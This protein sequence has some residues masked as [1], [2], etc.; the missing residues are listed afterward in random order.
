MT[1]TSALFDAYL[2]CPT[3]CWLR[4]TKKT[5]TGNTYAEWVKTQNESY[6]VVATERLLGQTPP[7]D[8]VLSP[9]IENLK[10]TKWRLALDVSLRTP[11]LPR[12]SRR[13][14][15]HSSFPQ[16]STL[17]S[18]PFEKSFVTSAAPDQAGV[19]P[20][21]CTAETH[22]HS[23]ER[24]PSEV[25]GKAA[26]FIPIRF[27]FTNKMGK[28]DKLLLA[29]DSFVLTAALGREI[30]FGKIIHGDDHATLKVKTSALADEVRKRLKKIAALLYNPTSPDLVLNR[31]CAECEFQARCRQKALE[32][33]DLSLL[34]GMNE[35]ERK[36]LH[37]KGI[38]TVTQLSYKFRPRRRPK[39][40]RDSLEKYH[41][42]LKALAI[43]EKKIYIVG[44]PELK[45]EGTPVYLDVEGLPDRDFYYL[46]GVR[47]GNGESAVQHSLWA[48]TFEDEGRI[49]KKFLAILETLEKPVLF[50]YG[51][52][53]IDFLKQMRE[54]HRV[55]PDNSLA[56]KKIGLTVNL[57]S[58]TFAQIYFPTYSN[59]LKELGVWLGCTWP[60]ET[61]SGIET[62]AHRN[63]WECCHG[64]NIWRALIEYNTGDCVALDVL[65]RAIFGLCQGRQPDAD[66]R[67]SGPIHTDTMQSDLPYRFGKVD[68]VLPEF[69]AFNKASYWDYE[70]V[71]LRC[72]AKLRKRQ[73]NKAR[74]VRKQRV[75]SKA[76]ESCLISICP[77]CKKTKINRQ[78]KK[79][80]VVFDIK[81]TRT[82]LRRNLIRYIYHC[83]KCQDCG[84]NFNDRPLQWPQH[85]EGSGLLAF[86][87]YQLIQQRLSWRMI[88]DGLSVFFGLERALGKVARLKDRAA[89]VY[90][91]TYEHLKKKLVSGQVIHA[92]ET[93]V[94]L[95]GKRSFVWVFSSITEAVF[96]HTD[97]REGDFLGEFFKGFKGVLVSD[98]YSAYDSIPCPQQKCLIHL[99]R[100]MNSDLLKH[101][102]DED[103]KQLARDF[104][105][106]LKPMVDT[107]DQFG[108]RA[109]FLRKHRRSVCSFYRD[110]ERRNFRSEIAEKYLNRFL[111]NRD[112]LFT[113]LEHDGV[114][115]NN[116][117]A[118]HAVKAFVFLR[119]V[120]GSSSTKRG[121]DDYLVLLSIYETC[122][123]NDVV[124]LDFLLSG[125]KDIHAFA[126]SRLGRRRRIPANKPKALPAEK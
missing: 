46:I 15:A 11:D 61:T 111:K 88:A 95:G 71:L 85:K 126:E 41:Y 57:L 109:R 31:H 55:P 44:R 119:K 74:S 5:P 16:P 2:K 123:R 108:F 103:M 99:M 54:R 98:F 6:R 3:K 73:K 17:S 106:L 27:I 67:V 1:I 93:H 9:S 105:N 29:F 113:F 12:S 21:T 116:N 84:T 107:V 79:E 122:K 125:E 18:Q 19:P 14:K 4:A 78:G 90:R 51:S 89:E 72:S 75:F 82:G 63:E 80:K 76:I 118:E 36:K 114:S 68:Y 69:E 92:D 91:G 49:W 115:W 59:G 97:T 30:T 48:D 62:I 10:T 7:A 120:I 58:V 94:S 42:S 39:R 8:S 32:Q 26:Q 124:F 101:P 13:Q 20:T 56:A 50:H 100:D 24:I 77:H 34:A 47:I 121:I 22:I 40:L 35:K 70:R 33:D 96:V 28:D 25:R 23:V 43:R 110:V 87:C 81:Y 45:I 66:P 60:D 53:E 52:Y 38:F 86:V 37:N 102:F 64:E 83:Y 112:R 117:S 65:S 104:A